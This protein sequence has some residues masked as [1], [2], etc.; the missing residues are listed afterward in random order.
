MKS[1]KTS[2]RDYSQMANPDPRCLPLIEIELDRIQALI[3]PA[4]K[5]AAIVSVERVEGRLVNTLYRVTPADGGIPL[6]LRIFA[7]GEFAWETE[8][9]ILARVSASLP[10]PQILLAGR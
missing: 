9:K 10:V 2:S 8:R 4:L 7:A 5:G 6:C 3:S 1:P